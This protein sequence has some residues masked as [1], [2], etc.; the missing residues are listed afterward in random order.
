MPI[1]E[2]YENLRNARGVK[3]AAV[4]KAT[5]LRRNLFTDW[6]NGKSYPK[7][8]KITALAAYFGVPF[9]LFYAEPGM[10]QTKAAANE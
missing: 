7:V 6:R 10:A 5:G 2:V 8:D 4:A 1:Y 3:D 9:A